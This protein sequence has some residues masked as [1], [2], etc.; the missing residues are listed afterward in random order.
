MDVQDGHAVDMSMLCTSV[1]F[2]QGKQV[3]YFFITNYCLLTDLK[4]L[5]DLLPAN[6][7][8]IMV[9]YK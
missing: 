3:N 5:I 8:A 7:W 4:L 9:V 1:H 2:I 6:I